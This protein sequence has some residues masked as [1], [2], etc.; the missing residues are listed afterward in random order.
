M[1][2]C[3][4]LFFR[5]IIKDHVGILR[6]HRARDTDKRAW[7]KQINRKDFKMTNSTVVCSNHFAAGYYNACN[8]P[9]LYLKGYTENSKKRKEPKPSENQ[10]QPD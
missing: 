2:N 10:H 5:Q 9:T 1:Y 8:I 3:S 7:E 6:W 4:L